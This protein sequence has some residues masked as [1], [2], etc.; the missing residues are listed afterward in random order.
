MTAFEQFLPI[1]MNLPSASNAASIF[2]KDTVPFFAHKVT[3]S[4]QHANGVAAGR[5][6]NRGTP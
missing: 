3:P 6:P 4:G 5:T 2:S 1:S